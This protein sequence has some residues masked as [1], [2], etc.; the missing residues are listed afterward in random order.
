MAVM[1][2]VREVRA[3]ILK[4]A[5]IATGEGAAST[6]LLG[7]MFHEV[8]ADL[9]GG[10]PGRNYLAALGEADPSPEEWR[11]A[12]VAHAY[13][14]LVGPRLRREQAA[15]HMVSD[16]VLVFWDAAQDLCGW[17][18]NLLWAAREQTG[19]LF[20]PSELIDVER[21]I[22]MTMR[23]AAWTDEVRLVGVADAVLRVPGRDQWCVIEL[24]TGRTSPEA[25]LAQASLYHLMLAEGDAASAGRM[26]LVSFEPGRRERLFDP[27]DLETAQHALTALIGRVAGVL[28]TVGA[29][30]LAVEPAPPPAAT[31]GRLEFGKPSPEHLELG[32]RLVRAILE[33]GVGVALEGEPVLSPTFIRFPMRLGAGVRFPAVQRAAADSQ[34]R[35]KLDA[36][37]TVG[38][39][40]GQV[41]IDLQRPDRQVVLFSRIRPQLPKTDP[42][43]GCSEAPLGVDIAG[44]LQT[45][46]FARPESAHLL[47][48]GTT[49]SGKSEWL[50]AAI[51]GLL[52]TNTPETLKLLPIDP[53]RSAF[54]MLRGSPYLLTGEIVYP[55]DAPIED[56]LDLLIQM[57]E[58]RY[59]I[60]GETDSDSLVDHIRRTGQQLPRIFCVCDEYADLILRDR[61]QRRLIED[62]ITRLGNKARAAGIHLIIAT[63][64]PSREVIKGALDATISARVGLKMQ[65][66]MES[67]M[68]LNADGAQNLLGRGDL[69]YKC[70]GAPVRLQSPYLP[71]DEMAEIFGAMGATSP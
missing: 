38:H 2:Q 64:Q 21:R 60:M 40:K 68:L 61:K 12:L 7:R 18:V 3:E 28:P 42:L 39:E 63:Q 46:D 50:R 6:A 45:L 16:R 10:D 9:V 15:L 36:A 69:L 58:S 34:F 26:A 41:V 47:V 4:S 13:R 25:D 14:V 52:V 5:G 54:Q 8:F 31:N 44:R 29:P 62:R 23:D 33:F 65:K 66:A 70:I 51:A 55:E 22:E 53:K 11:R 35:L 49:G 1:L 67:K 56:V 43:T 48:A 32:R 20:S 27:Q 59:S 71:A 30:A 37:P 17:L 19:K 57:M 24:K